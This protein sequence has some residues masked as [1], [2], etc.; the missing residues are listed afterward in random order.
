MTRF[1]T[2]LS[3]AEMNMDPEFDFNPG[4]PEVSNQHQGDRYV[5]CGDRHFSSVDAPWRAELPGGQ[6]V[7]GLGAGTWPYTTEDLP[8]NQIIQQLSVTGPGQEVFN[9]SD[10]IDQ[11]LASDGQRIIDQLPPDMVPP[12]MPP[13]GDT[14]NGDAN[15]GDANNGAINGAD[16]NNATTGDDDGGCSTAPTRRA[17]ARSPLLL[18]AALALLALRTAQNTPPENTPPSNSSA[19]PPL[20][21]TPSMTT[22][23]ACHLLLT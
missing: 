15:N 6:I 13:R 1:Y 20:Q 21:K 3:P 7:Y 22:S 8:A 18:L 19:R 23:I 14:N 9:N 2:T 10:A 17:P 4:L 12:M 11:R 5:F 16:T